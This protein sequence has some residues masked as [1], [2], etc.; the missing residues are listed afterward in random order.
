MANAAPAVAQSPAVPPAGMESFAKLFEESLTRKE[1]R[2]QG[3]QM[4]PNW[5]APALLGLAMLL[6]GAY[7]YRLAEA[8]EDVAGRRVRRVQV[9]QVQVRPV[10][11]PQVLAREVL[12]R[13]INEKIH[14][15]M[16]DEYGIK[17]DD[18]AVSQAEQSVARQNN[19]SIEEMHRRLAADGISVT[20]VVLT[21]LA[22]VAGVLFSWN[23]EHR[24][25]EFF[26]YFFALI[27]GVYGVF[28]SLDLFLLFVFYEIAI[29]PKYFLIAIWGSTRR[30]YAAMKL[31][32]Y[33]FIGVAVTSATT[34]ICGSASSDGALAG[35]G[36]AEPV[37]YLST[38]SPT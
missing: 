26:A 38:R 23:V 27:G 8:F 15:Q 11:L 34:I 5:W 33:S 6:V 20:L 17:V 30:D 28:L 13:L 7:G 3:P 4:R 35:R 32:L 12:E 24:T 9:R 36:V 37:K 19:V 22:A 2:D 29:V 31:A 14:V 25:N 1:M 10:P 16:A 18:Y 21:G